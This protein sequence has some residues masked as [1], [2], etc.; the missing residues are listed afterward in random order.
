MERNRSLN[1][2]SPKRGSKIIVGILIAIIAIVIFAFFTIYYYTSNS[3]FGNA[4]SLYYE[5]K[6]VEAR[7]AFEELLTTSLYPNKCLWWIEKCN[8]AIEGIDKNK[9]IEEV[10]LQHGLDEY[11]DITEHG[12]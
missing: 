2:N 5:G 12:E 4:V 1:K 8:E 11:S 3:T 6:F 9:H 7:I 10:Q